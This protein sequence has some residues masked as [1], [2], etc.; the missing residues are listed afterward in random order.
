MILNSCWKFLIFGGCV[1][2]DWY[3]FSIVFIGFLYFLHVRLAY[4]FILLIVPII[5]SM[6][7]STGMDYDHYKFDF[8]SGFFS[9]VPP[10]FYTQGGLTAEPFYKIYTGFI[11]VIT[12]FD[13]E[14]FLIV[15]FFICFSIFHY[16]VDLKGNKEQVRVKPLFWL[17]LLPVVV[18]TVFYFS[19]RSSLSFFLMLGGFFSLY[20]GKRI[21]AFI[22]FF[23]TV[24]THSQFLP[25]IGYFLLVF[26]SLR[27]VIDKCAHKSYYYLFFYSALL[28]IFL[29]FMPLILGFVSALLSFLPSADVATSKLH[30]LE[31]ANQGFRATSFLSVVVF[32]CLVLIL[33]RYKERVR[34]KLGLSSEQVWRLTFFLSVCVSFGFVINVVYIDTP[35]L[36]GRLARFSDYTNLA[37]LM[38]ISLLCFFS[39]R[40]VIAIGLLFIVAAPFLYPTVYSI[41]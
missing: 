33:F 20:H 19:P 2:I 41:H 18:P 11:R 1:T 8:E 7:L 10:F 29:F 28:M 9:L 37:L 23:L 32:P 16:T 30:Y 22:L 35:H 14:I 6:L 27:K 38:P 31:T 12:G 15:N 25:A 36:S 21:N 5:L 39:T 4:G 3:Y 13:F 34:L 26:L 17:F 40:V 24:C